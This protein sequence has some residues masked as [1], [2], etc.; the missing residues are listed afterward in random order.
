MILFK[1]KCDYIFQV[2]MGKG[3]TSPNDPDDVFLSRWKKTQL[4]CCFFLCFIASFSTKS[5]VL[6][7]ENLSLSNKINLRFKQNE[8]MTLKKEEEE[9]EEELRTEENV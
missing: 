6:L 2:S 4:F 9:E 3:K 5:S 7:F 8:T 1:K